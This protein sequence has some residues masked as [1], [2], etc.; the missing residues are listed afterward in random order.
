[1]VF[2]GIFESSEKVE[3]DDIKNDVSSEIKL[4]FENIIRRNVSVEDIQSA[5]EKIIR[6]VF[7][8]SRG[9]KPVVIVHVLGE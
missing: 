2:S 9:K 7:I 5:V 4:S 1:M 3:M 6:T 8:D